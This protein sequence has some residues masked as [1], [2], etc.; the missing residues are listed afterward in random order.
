MHALA[1]DSFCSMR[2]A[3]LVYIAQGVGVVFETL[4]QHGLRH[5]T[6]REL[7]LS[8][9]LSRLLGYV[10]VMLFLTATFS[11]AAVAGRSFNKGQ[12]DDWRLDAI[13]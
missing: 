3:L 8:P 6:P 4:A 12:V 1:M 10:W 9:L 2:I 5:G 7:K 13:T 11:S